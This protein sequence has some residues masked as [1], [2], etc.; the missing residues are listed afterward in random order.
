MT[1]VM[2][3]VVWKKVIKSCVRQ[4][5]TGAIIYPCRTLPVTHASLVVTV[6]IF[7]ISNTY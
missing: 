4:S 5:V 2:A 1:C 6:S 3:S 7:L